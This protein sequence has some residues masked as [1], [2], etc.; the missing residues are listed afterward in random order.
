[1]RKGLRPAVLHPRAL[2]FS[3]GTCSPQPALRGFPRKCTCPAV[4]TSCC[5]TEEKAQPCSQTW[6][7]QYTNHLLQS[8]QPTALCVRQLN[9]L[10]LIT[11]SNWDKET[12]TTK[13][14]A[15]NSQAKYRQCAAESSKSPSQS[16]A[17]HTHTHHLPDTAQEM[18][19]STFPALSAR[20][21]LPRPHQHCQPCAA[22]HARSTQRCASRGS[23]VAF[24]RCCT[25]ARLANTRPALPHG[26]Q[27]PGRG[28]EPS[29]AL[30]LSQLG[31]RR[32]ER[33]LP[34]PQPHQQSAEQ[35][36]P[37][38]EKEGGRRGGLQ[39]RPYG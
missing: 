12:Q 10:Q 8:P 5:R 33:A 15:R 3:G 22:A 31:H 1:M 24:S 7:V 34:V 4:L 38:G 37:A 13:P 32:R 16:R 11:C 26:L 6:T 9:S 29:A 19:S 30:Q 2:P 14:R 18:L 25:K 28:S 17:A 39:A 20:C 27:V 23:Q 21:Q 36:R 35:E